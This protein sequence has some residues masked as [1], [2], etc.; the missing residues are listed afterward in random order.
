MVVGPSYTSLPKDGSNLWKVCLA[1]THVEGHMGDSFRG[2]Q[3][4]RVNGEFGT[5]KRDGRTLELAPLGL[6]PLFAPISP[7]PPHHLSRRS[8]LQSLAPI[9][10]PRCI[11]PSST[12]VG[13]S[14][15]REVGLGSR[16]TPGERL[17]PPMF[18]RWGSWVGALILGGRVPQT[19]SDL[20]P[21]MNSC[22][23]NWY[24]HPQDMWG[25]GEVADN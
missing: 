12:K 20:P 14:P 4:F 6:V 22:F 21:P 19:P 16:S 17:N 10:G 15:Q 23:E 1:G 2:F 18:S 5:E 7:H 9:L 11:R 25:Q 24:L 3:R 13:A 8:L